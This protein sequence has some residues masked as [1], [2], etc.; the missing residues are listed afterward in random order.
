MI[1]DKL[2]LRVTEVVRETDQVIA[3]TLAQSDGADL[4]V[5]EP[6]AHLEFTLPSGLI[7]H[8]S[9]CG[10]PRDRGSYTVAVLRELTGRGGSKELHEIARA[11]LDLVVRAPRNNFPLETA[12]EYLFLA[13]GIGITP[14]LAMIRVVEASGRAWRLV[15]GGRSRASMA[16]LPE[17]AG[18]L[19][20]PESHAESLVIHPEDELGFPDFAAEFA[21]LGPNALVYACGPTPMLDALSALAERDGWR[22]W[23]RVERFTANPDDVDLDGD[24]FE[25]ELARGK[26]S[27]IVPSGVSILDA[28][29]PIVPNVAFSCEEGH[30]GTCE[31]VVLDGVPDHRDS[32][33]DDDEH[34]SNETMMICVSRSLSKRLVLDL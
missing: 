31:T 34:E 32:Y 16:F 14:I 23:L 13:G 29:R 15:Y 4:P 9:L 10:D 25:V 3:V 6:G 5:W 18:L 1:A 19:T 27:V 22:D 21:K 24:A 28:V 20:D 12:A 7:R 26:A 33:L 30:C 8:Y 2:T 17:L 11:G